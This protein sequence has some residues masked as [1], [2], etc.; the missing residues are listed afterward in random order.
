MPMTFAEKAIAFYTDLQ[1]PA[2][3]LPHSVE[4]INPY[5][6]LPIQRIVK[7]F[8]EKFFSD[9]KQRVLVLGINPGRFGGAVTGVSFT[10]PVNLAKYC[11]ITHKLKPRT[12]LSSQFVYTCIE[13]SGG[14]AAFYQR[15]YLGALYPLALVKEGK[16]YNYYD[17]PEVFAA[18]KPAIIDSLK[19][20]A[21]FGS[22]ISMIC[23]GQKNYTYLQLI[24]QEIKLFDTIHV[25]DHPRF[26]MQYRRKEINNYVDQY[27]AVFEKA[28]P[29]S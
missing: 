29:G 9:N 8:Y 2:E 4:I 24:N 1:A 17:T 23:L 27:R 22:S 20:Q 28:F 15:F 13:A 21:G 16:N 19:A 26:I 18:L 6:G 5:G 14:A 7:Q 25:L 3:P 11:G 12:E 10:D